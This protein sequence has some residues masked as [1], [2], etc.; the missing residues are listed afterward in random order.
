MEAAEH[1]FNI[2]V[3]LGVGTDLNGKL[4]KHMYAPDLGPNVPS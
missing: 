4:T 3:T 2:C 1:V